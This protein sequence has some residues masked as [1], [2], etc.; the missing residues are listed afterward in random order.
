MLLY[1]TGFYRHYTSSKKEKKKTGSTY[2]SPTGICL[3]TEADF[4]DQSHVYVRNWVLPVAEEGCWE[5]LLRVE[6]DV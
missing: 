3:C 2:I 6:G 1:L 5:A 4:I